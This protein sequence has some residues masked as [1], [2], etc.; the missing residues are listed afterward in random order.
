MHR[1]APGYAAVSFEKKVEY[2]IVW[3]KT[4]F[5]LIWSC[6]WTSTDQRDE[7][8]LWSRSVRLASNLAKDGRWSPSSRT[9]VLTGN[10]KSRQ[11]PCRVQRWRAEVVR[12]VSAARLADLELEK[13]EPKPKHTVNTTEAPCPMEVVLDM[14]M[15]QRNSMT[16][17]I[18]HDR[19]GPDQFLLH[20]S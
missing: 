20:L 7:G 1:C 17:P 6:M 18:P 14:A 19:A 4:A 9:H 11:A 5:A 15:P 16:L 3:E 8:R 13:H 10:G 12:Q 2:V